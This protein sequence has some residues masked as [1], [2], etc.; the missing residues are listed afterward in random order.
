MKKSK[1]KKIS[2]K[3]TLP[4]WMK[5]LL[6]CFIMI[7][8]AVVYFYLNRMPYAHPMEVQEQAILTSHQD[9]KLYA[10]LQ[11]PQSQALPVGQQVTVKQYHLLKQ[12]ESS[13]P[14][15]Y[16]Q[17]ELEGEIFYTHAG[18]LS[19]L[20]T[21]PINQ[22]V[23]KLGYPDFHITQD[24]HSVFPKWNYAGEH[25][26]GILVH[27]TGNDTSTLENEIR[28]ME[29][30]FSKSGVFVHT[31]I[32][33]QEIRTIASTDFMAQGAGPRANPRF[34]QFELIRETSKEGFVE[35]I[36]QAA[37]YTA[38]MLRTYDLPLTLGQED[39]SGTLWT[40]E[41]VSHY[42]GG[43]DHIDPRDYWSS[44]A[45]K[46]FQTTYGIENFKELVQV[47]YNKLKL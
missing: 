31:F 40:H 27:D 23:E 39:G 29:R 6:A 7:L 35:E 22:E 33:S 44:M 43:T 42:L 17:I 9:D 47:Y 15:V 36:A 41:I 4:L 38:L 13:H 5:G 8:G 12:S 25:P 2:Q 3:R 30:N 18:N 20:I 19:L 26:A 28:Y 24:I 21:N 10:E 14:Q 32:N 34:I 1:K 45:E 11:S 46:H 16:A 37:Y